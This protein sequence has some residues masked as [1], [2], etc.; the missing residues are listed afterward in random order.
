MMSRVPPAPGAHRVQVGGAEPLVKEVVVPGAKTF[1]LGIGLMG[2]GV[3]AAGCVDR[4]P[5]PPDAF[6]PQDRGALRTQ[7]PIKPDARPGEDDDES[8]GALPPPPFNDA[9]LVSQE[10]PEQQAFVDAYNSV[11]RPRMV[12]FVNRTLEGELLPVNADDPVASV[13]RTR[14][15]RGDVTVESR[16]R[17]NTDARVRDRYSDADAR[18]D[19]DTTDRFEARGGGPN[20]YR[21]RVDLYLR[22]GQYD[23]ASARQID[24]EAIET[25]LTDWLAAGGRTEVVSPLTARQRLTDE[26]VKDLHGGRPRVMG[27][28]ARELDADVLVHVSARPTRQTRRGLEVRLVAEAIN[29]RGGQSIGRAVVDIFPPLDKPRINKFTRYL[30]RGLMDRMIG[31]WENAPAPR[32]GERGPRDPGRGEEGEPRGFGPRRDPAGDVIPQDLPPV[33]PAAPRD[34]AAPAPNLPPG[35]GIEQPAAPEPAPGPRAESFPAAPPPTGDASVTIEP[36]PNK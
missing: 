31:A 36:A 34:P 25:I 5:P 10:T 6:V 2:F 15:S 35:R 9:P 1:V 19:R 23:E 16:E 12:V 21:D 26:Q 24:Y 30:A 32:E 27:E 17:R 13:E 14:R 8:A 28:L 4:T 22:P 20:E 11:G 29:V 33:D 7:D 3:V 18:S